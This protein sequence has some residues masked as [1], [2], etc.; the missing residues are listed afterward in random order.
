MNILLDTG[1]IG[2]RNTHP[3]GG[4][5]SWCYRTWLWGSVSLK[6]VEW[7]SLLWTSGLTFYLPR[8]LSPLVSVLTHF[9]VLLSQR[10]TQSCTF[11]SFNFL[12]HNIAFFLWS[13]LLLSVFLLSLILFPTSL[14][15]SDLSTLHLLLLQ[16]TLSESQIKAGL[17]LEEFW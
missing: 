3:H 9:P 2:T 5:S 10:T 8:S 4:A 17:C 11:P 12:S 6:K 16:W 15:L 1:E 7:F 13:I 14:L